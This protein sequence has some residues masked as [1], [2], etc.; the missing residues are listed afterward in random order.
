VF[1]NVGVGAHVTR[2]II[3]P[4]LVSGGFFKT[5]GYKERYLQKTVTP[6]PRLMSNVLQ[7]Q[8]KNGKTSEIIF[9]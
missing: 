2:A 4:S 1:I 7:Q 3:Y 9:R 8:K 5:L 6:L